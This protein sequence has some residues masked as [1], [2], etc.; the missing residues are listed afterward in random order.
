MD[1]DATARELVYLE[2]TLKSMSKEKERLDK[3]SQ[4]ARDELKNAE[5]KDRI[6]LGIIREST[7]CLKKLSQLPHVACPGGVL[8]RPCLLLCSLSIVR[9]AAVLRVDLSTESS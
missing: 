2:E 7:E 1:K 6:L 9:S 5:H 8:P 4:E 3:E